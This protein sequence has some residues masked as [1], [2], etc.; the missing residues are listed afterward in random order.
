MSWG[1]DKLGVSEATF[2]MIKAATTGINTSTGIA[3]IHM[4]DLV[5]LVPV[6][7]PF[8]NSTPRHPAPVGALFAVWQALLNVNQTQPNGGIQN[9]Q[10]AP[11][12]KIQDQYMYAPYAVI[13]AGGTT[14]WDALA[15]GQNYADV[16]AVD[17]LQTIN[18]Q[19][20]FLDIHQLNA[21]SFAAPTATTP[22]VVA[23]TSGGSIATGKKVSVKVSVRTGLNYY[24]G[25]GQTATA[26]GHATTTANTSSV[27]AKVPAVK[28][29]AAYDWFAG[30]TTGTF[31]YYTTTAVN[32]VT[33][34]KKI[35][36][37]QNVPTTLAL[38]YNAGNAG[39]S[40]P[41][42]STTH[43]TYW[44]NGLLATIFGNYSS[45]PDQLG[46]AGQVANLV[47]PG[48]GTTNG[49]YY[50]SLTGGT[51]T[52][53]GAAIT[54]IDAMNRRIYDKWQLTPTRMLMG[55]QVINDL[56]NALLDNP[57]AVT[58]LVPTDAS[59]RAR[60]V[61]GGAVAI[62]LNKT[63]NGRPITL[64]L[65]PHLPPGKIVSVVDSIPFPGANITT[66]LSVET[67][68]DFFRF[69]YGAN[70]VLT[71]ESNSGGGPRYDFEVRTKQAFLN[72][73]APVFGVLDNIAP[74]LS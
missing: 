9:Q 32:T 41:G 12:I 39:P 49:A 18:Q 28:T 51:L 57:Q 64:E 72:K 59:G 35:T 56:A 20:I 71:T 52:V 65:Q 36:A 10:A 19:L 34:T 7:T 46:V 13:G 54:Q 8:F 50:Q 66:V 14:S 11:L 45:S 6:D 73:A 27:T 69:D 23:H 48:T 40:V 3:G 74:G 15:Q 55:S 60:L 63:V 68:Y 21:Q 37:I 58:W 62:Y 43:Q 33:I 31:Y 25:G 24:Y 16:L 2:D 53:N 17:T 38:L 4:S 44:E 30:Y 67:L 22:T 70:R 42:S 5:S 61:A 47:T 26:A 29:A 1:S